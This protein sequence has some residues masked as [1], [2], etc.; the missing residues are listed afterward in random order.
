MDFPEY[1]CSFRENSG[2]HFSY[3]KG[4]AVAELTM[5]HE[6]CQSLPKPGF[7]FGFAVDYLLAE[8]HDPA[9]KEK[10][11]RGELR[12]D[13]RRDSILARAGLRSGM[14]YDEICAK[15]GGHSADKLLSV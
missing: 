4:G 8:I 14:C 10:H 12:V 2:W 9:G 7:S 3:Q 13:P 6:E 11:A 5:T 15:A 1:I